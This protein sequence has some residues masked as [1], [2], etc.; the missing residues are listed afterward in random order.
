[1]PKKKY[2][3]FEENIIS[4]F[5][6]GDK[7]EIDG[8]I[9]T[10]EI[11]GKPKSPTAGGEPKT[12]CYIKGVSNSKNVKELKISC[13]KN[14]KEFIEN[15]MSA[16]RAEE[17]FGSG[18][19]I[20]I[21]TCTE[22]IINKFLSECLVKETSRNGTPKRRV[23]LGWRVDVTEKEGKL[24]VPLEILTEKEI[25]DRIYKGIGS[26]KE[27]SIIDGEEIEG[28]GIAEYLLFGKESSYST[29]AEVIENLIPID[30]YELPDLYIVFT[31]CTHNITDDNY[32]KRELAAAVKWNKVENLMKPDL[33]L[34]KPLSLDMKSEKMA[35]RIKPYLNGEDITFQDKF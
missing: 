1:M 13:K 9:F 31:G 2:S 24:S 33:L 11:S 35:A 29:T 18:Y 15:K 30:E 34:E 14:N 32:E 26:S 3:L 6:K 22:K 25:K 16:Q 23:T 10:V 8:E 27:D 19:E 17:I 21:E 5:S 12:D 7:F 4:L 20:Y 28:S